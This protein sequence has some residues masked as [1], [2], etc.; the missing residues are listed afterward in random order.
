[1]HE[2]AK[3]LGAGRPRGTACINEQPGDGREPIQSSNE[4]WPVCSPALQDYTSPP[5]LMGCTVSLTNS[6]LCS[7]TK[8][9]E[10]FFFEVVGGFGSEKTRVPPFPWPPPSV[11]FLFV[12]FFPSS[13]TAH[14]W[15]S[16]CG[17]ADRN[18]SG[19]EQGAD[20]EISGEAGGGV[21]G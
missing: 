17:P 9:D 20:R 21:A 19:G 7:P 13:R 8:R 18:I 5:A 14:C 16:V 6:L 4:P 10:F 2:L 12:C 11:F 3:A 15:R 1:M